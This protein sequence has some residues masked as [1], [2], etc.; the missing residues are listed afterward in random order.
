MTVSYSF[1]NEN[2]KL[3]NHRYFFDRLA[4]ERNRMLIKSA[5]VSTT[6]Y[7][8]AILEG[9]SMFREKSAQINFKSDN[10]CTHNHEYTWLKLINDFCVTV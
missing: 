6:K 4:L 2:F 7:G 1:M 9:T 8:L 5:A 10:P 3:F